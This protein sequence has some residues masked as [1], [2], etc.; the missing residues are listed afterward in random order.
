MSVLLR[1]LD[2]G[3]LTGAAGGDPWQL[4]KTMQSGSPGAISELA[5]A[6]Y[7]AG[8]CA[9]ETDEEFNAARQRF[10]SAWDRQDGGDHPINDSDEVRRATE[11]LHLTRQ[12][13]TRVGV[14]LQNVS[15]SLAEAQRSG[16]ISISNLE[17]RL[18]A[19]DDQI[20]RE[21]ATAAANG[22]DVDWSDLK[23]AAIDATTQGLHEIH[24]IRDAYSKQLD[25]SRGEMA[26]EGYTPEATTAVDGE[27][28]VSTNEEA[29]A[30]AGKYGETQRAADESLVH[31][32]GPWTP[33]KQAAAGR[34]RDFATIN[35]P[36]AGVDEVR[37]AGERLNDYRMSQFSGPLPTDTVMGGD[38]RTRAQARLQMQQRL[39]SPYALPGK[40]PL[41]PDQAT[42]LLN[43]WEANGRGMVLHQFATQLQQA[44]VS[45]QGTQQAVNEIQNGASPG[46]VIK[47]A[48]AGLAT[49][50]TNL[51]EGAKAHA[52]ALPG[53][54][55][56]GNAPVWSN[57][58]AEALKGFGSKLGTAGTVVDGLLT[59]NDVL[60][61]APAFEEGAQ[62]GG[63]TLGAMGGGWL[64]GA[65]W[66]SLVGPEGTLVVGFLGALGGGIGGEKFV[67]WM[68]GK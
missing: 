45:A 68:M 16:G 55:H 12:Q 56:W 31:S 15:A 62:F 49:Q 51:G 8:V 26:A 63:R 58:D 40:P 50:A 47:E 5:T 1:H 39:E 11:S 54:G 37:Y 44:G 48:T 67:D 66:G 59:I 29:H 6:F 52:E 22:Q 30:E 24:A 64:A 4:N 23:Q 46:E 25:A 21:I 35:N 13:M 20:D 61:G 65:A 38:A 10:A 57:A 41:T 34:L 3:E 7:E 18:Q 33:E 53:G 32:P 43:Q 27:A 2:I 17:T 36:T 14:D 19:I 28:D 9:Q 42:Q 60:H